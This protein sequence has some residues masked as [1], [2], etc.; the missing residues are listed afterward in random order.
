M[1]AFA[2]GFPNLC[3]FFHFNP[4]KLKTWSQE[5]CK[6]ERNVFF[7]V[8]HHSFP[9]KKNPTF[10]DKKT[11]HF[12]HSSSGFQRNSL[13]FQTSSGPWGPWGPAGQMAALGTKSVNNSEAVD[14]GSL[15]ARLF[16]FQETI[17]KMV[18][19]SHNYGKSPFFSK[20]GTYNYS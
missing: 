13:D 17:G 7:S 15:M 1:P 19:L 12:H 20:Y 16:F 10:P 8:E 18:N 3:F 9:D 6:L 4:L 5:K 2:F 11:R 14:G